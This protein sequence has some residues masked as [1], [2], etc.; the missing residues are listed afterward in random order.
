MKT[1][2]VVGA[3]GKM[4]SA[5]CKKLE[6][7]FKLVKIDIGDRLEDAGKLDLVID[8]GSHLSSVISAKFCR[9]N[10]VRLLVGST[11]QSKEEMAV[12]ENASKHVP[13]L[14]AGNFSV[15]VSLLKKTLSQVLKIGADDVVI[16]EKHHRQKADSPSGTALEIAG[17]I[18]KQTNRF[19][20]ILS[21][22]GGKEIGTHT[23]DIY[24]GDEVLRFEHQAFSRDVFADGAKLAAKFLLSKNKPAM[25]S[26]DDVLRDKK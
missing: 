24:F 2:A 4:G 18:E 10:H 15:G 6:N 20:Q 16:I 14:V 13:V 11:G 19:P 3:N 22:R 5:V 8:F 21:E 1:I 12:I 7:D 26:F 17:V 25:L 23:I 9:E